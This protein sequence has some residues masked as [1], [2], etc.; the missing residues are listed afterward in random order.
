MNENQVGSLA[1]VVF[2]LTALPVLHLSVVDFEN[3]T[4]SDADFVAHIADRYVSISIASGVGLLLVGVLVVHISWLKG[5]LSIHARNGARIAHNC[6]LITASALA[7]GFGLS[8]VT[9]YGAHEKFPDI[10]VRTVAMLAENLGT[11]LMIGLAAFAAL[12][13][14]LGWRKKFPLW[15]TLIA[16]LETLITLAAMVGGV[17]AAAAIVT[18]VWILVNSIGMA[19]QGRK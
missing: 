19:R 15:L 9:S 8:I 17:P 11:S 10:S 16:T 12:I 5:L 1:G 2:G 6:A 7:I 14:L 13:A 4:A 18:I 3:K